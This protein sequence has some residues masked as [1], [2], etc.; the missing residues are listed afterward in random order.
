MLSGDDK[1]VWDFYRAFLAIV[2]RNENINIKVKESY[3]NFLNYFRIIFLDKKQTELV[4]SEL[5][6]IEN[7]QCRKWLLEVCVKD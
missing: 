4:I 1:Y 7:I 6:K 2:S 5:Q 3:L